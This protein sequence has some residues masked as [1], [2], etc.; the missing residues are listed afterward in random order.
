MS[1]DLSIQRV[2]LW[3]VACV[4]YMVLPLLVSPFISNFAAHWFPVIVINFCIIAFLAM[5]PPEFPKIRAFSKKVLMKFSGL[6]AT[7]LLMTVGI[8]LEH[9]SD[10]T[11]SQYGTICMFVSIILGVF[12]MDYIFG[13]K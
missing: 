1:S 12:V 9:L 6:F 11:V 13:E 7:H 4:M 10:E 2:H 5:A 3:A 8:I